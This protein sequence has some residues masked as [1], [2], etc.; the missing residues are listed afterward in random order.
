MVGGCLLIAK[1]TGATPFPESRCGGDKMQ[2]NSELRALARAIEPFAPE[3]SVS[4]VAERFLSVDLAEVLSVPIVDGKGLVLGSISRY[5]LNGIFMSKFG[6]DLYGARPISQFMSTECLR[7]DVGMPIA[8]AAQYVTTR[9]SVPLSED[10]IV[11]AGGC[12]VGVGAVLGLLA[13]MEREVR[14]GALQ[15]EHAYRKLQ[16]SQAQL[17]QSE[18][19]ASLG[20]MVAG[21]AHE[22]NTPLGYVRNNL[23]LMREFGGQV[24]EFVDAA[25]ALVNALLDPQGSDVEVANRLAAL[26]DLRSLVD[27]EL[28]FADMDTLLGDTGFGLAQISELV[29]GLKNFSRLDQAFTDNVSLNDCINSALLIAKNAIKNKVE[30]IRQLGEIPAVSCAP[31]QINQVLLNL[32]TNAAQAIDD[33]GKLVI[34][35]WAD[36]A[37]VFVSV[38]DTGKG[39]PAEHLKKIFDPFY[40]TKPVGEGTGLG[41][42][43]CWQ[44]IQQHGGRIQVASEPGRGTRFVITLP[45]QSARPQ[46]VAVAAIAS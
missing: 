20:Q 37:R 35:T 25:I 9:M 40:T 10:F 31:S 16:S 11:C 12:Y 24:R 26:E 41:L 22:I 38:Q 21:V 7:V 34:R 6:R 39:I 17:V 43:I 19:M 45:M 32:F 4:E 36:E 28:L 23:E 13:A 44:I 14:S 1:C 3:D 18:K 30:V 33:R 15:L 29:M 42:S 8:E 5:Q 27:P 46:A 2:A